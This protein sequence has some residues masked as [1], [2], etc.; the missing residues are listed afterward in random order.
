MH[1]RKLP[2]TALRA[3]AM[4]AQLGSVSRAAEELGVSHGAVSR[5]ISSLES[6]LG[7][8]LFDRRGKRLELTPPGLLFADNIGRSMREIVVACTEIGN[9]SNRRIISVEAPATFAMYWLLPRVRQY[10]KIERNIEINVTTRM[11]NDPPG[12]SGS[13]ILVTRGMPH[14]RAQSYANSNVLFQEEMTVIASS[15]YFKRHA[16]GTAED[17]L[18]CPRV[19][20]STRPED[21]SQWIALFANVDAPST[22]RHK[23]DHLFVAMHAV[24]DGIGSIVAPINLFAPFDS[25]KFIAAFPHMTFAGK[26]Y[27]VHSKSKREANFLKKFLNWLHECSDRDKK[28][29]KQKFKTSPRLRTP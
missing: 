22:V 6:L 13:D 18:F 9:S 10:E 17:V 7:M 27:V 21:W 12:F 11:S 23:F 14:G 29:S 8:K 3:F 16:I 26:P 2:L 1:I 4:T 15:A 5:N 25:T 19:S 28:T 24:A 20:T